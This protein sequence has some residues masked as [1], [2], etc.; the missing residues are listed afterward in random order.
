M[1][2]KKQLRQSMQ[3]QRLALSPA[4]QNNAAMGLLKVLSDSLLFKKSQHIAFYLA[5]SGE[6]DPHPLIEFAW[7][8]NQSCYLPLLAS[9]G[10][11]YLHFAPYTQ[12]SILVNNRYGIPEPI[13]SQ[14]ELRLPQT[15]DLVFVPLVAVDAEGN[16]LGMGK[17]YYDRT[18][19]FLCSNP[20][21]IK[22]SL[23]GLGHSFQQTDQIVPC[24]WDVP[25]Q[26][27]ATESALTFFNS[28][29]FG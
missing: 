14:E 5:N 27:V 15:L 22:P 4:Q 16:R 8:N 7:Q 20:R 28:P 25:I 3:R 11:N 2:D 18:F 23:I 9:N 1:V 26:G 21:P 13:C 6:I 12:D 17:G 24:S 29:V 10:D 19:A